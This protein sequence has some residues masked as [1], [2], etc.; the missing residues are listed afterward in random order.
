MSGIK[1]VAEATTARLASLIGGTVTIPGDPDYDAQRAAWNLAVDQ[2]P[3]VII[4]A[5]GVGD[6]VA[7]VRYAAAHGMGLAI[8]ATGHGVA[9][10]ANDTVLLLTGDLNQV[11]VNARAATA[12][13]EAGAKWGSVLDKAAPH[14]LAPLLGS[15]PDVGAV[16]YTLGG[17]LGWLA[18]KHGLAADSVRFF[19][20]VTSD[21]ELMRASTEENADL[22][23][24]LRGGGAGSLGVIAAMEI[25]L[26]PVEGVYGGNLLYPAAMTAEVAARYSEWIAQ[27][28]EEL[29]SS[30]VLMNFPPMELVPEPLRGRSFAIVR[31]CHCG[32][33][34]D[35]EA[36]L[37]FWRTWK[38]PEIDL[39]G[40]M[41]F[42]AVATVSADPV[43]PMPSGASTD[44]LKALNPDVVETLVDHTF[45]SGAPPV[46]TFAEV[47]HIGG[48]VSRGGRH[49]AAYGN[50]D[51]HLLLEVV[52]LAP[53]PDAK[54]VL[55]DHIGR[56]HQRLRPHSTGGA[57][58]NF[59]E[60]E[61]KIQ[62]TKAGFAPEDYARL[63]ALKRQFD[64]QNLFRHGVDLAGA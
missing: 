53:S 56:L 25:D 34:A 59:L 64:P 19:E 57:Y 37:A 63:R 17:G 52:G 32:S 1:Q 12:R 22:F 13:V 48:A 40:P 16:G 43:D 30:L 49:P 14:G 29:T 9:R 58:L 54:A 20:I 18:R 60:G 3:A 46:L 8:Q 26:V 45:T 35:A 33:P 61:E 6:L 23:W 41:P 39:F 55:D 62:R 24:G 7:A 21:G 38:Q 5:A 4:R 15:S 10:P 27:A 42:S 11:Q 51:A 28:P 31:G 36:Q 44:W 50:R 47:R 2:H